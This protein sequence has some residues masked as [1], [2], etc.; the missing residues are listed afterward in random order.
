MNHRITLASALLFSLLAVSK[1][2]TAETYAERQL[3]RVPVACATES[4]SNDPAAHTGEAPDAHAGET[5]NAHAGEA[6]NAHAGEVPATNTPEGITIETAGPGTLDIELTFMGDIS[7]NEDTMAHVT[8]RVPGTVIEIR[9]TLGDTVKKGDVL[10]V[11]ASRELADAKAE[12][13]AARER[14]DLAQSRFDR[15]DHLYQQKLSSESVYLD[16]KQVYADARITLR[17]SHQKLHALGLTTNDLARLPTLPDDQLTSLEI[18]APL[19]GTIIE[20]HLT[21]GEV[22]KDEYDDHPNFIIA[23]LRTVWANL[24]VFPA[25]LPRVQAGQ[26]VVISVGDDLPAVR[27]VIGYVGPVVL[28]DTRTA[29]ARVVVA[30]TDGKL[31][32]G[33]FITGKVTI[34]TV[35][36]AVCLPSAAV[37]TIANK[38]IV[39][40]QDA[41]GLEPR[42]VTLGAADDTRVEITSG[43]KPGDKYVTRGAFELKAKQ[44]TAGMDSHAGHGH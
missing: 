30:N 43:V 4:L 16:A 37:Q 20:K 42:P 13:L 9:K 38:P 28:E 8:A 41:H 15:E 3:D 39:F 24:R 21:I 11:I 7:V 40:I 23:D 36:A 32:P 27:A 33:E 29:L 35:A 10:A 44:I 18:V 17:S 1:G 14:S 6:P 19:D 2:A 22:L 5:P 31:R 25:D 34:G 26:P 12:Y